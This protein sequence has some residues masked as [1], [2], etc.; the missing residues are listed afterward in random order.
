MVK[1]SHVKPF[2]VEIAV[3]LLGLE[4]SP[5]SDGV[6]TNMSVMDGHL[7]VHLLDCRC[8]N[9]WINSTVPGVPMSSRNAKLRLVGG[10]GCWSGCKG[11][12]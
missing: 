7:Y 1:W 8:N 9:R 10:S 12:A 2:S 6:E 5:R 4:S 11:P 3:C